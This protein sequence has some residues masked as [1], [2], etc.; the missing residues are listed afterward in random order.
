MFDSRTKTSTELWVELLKEG[1]EKAR[2][3]LTELQ[4]S[5]TVFMLQR[6][7]KRTDFGSIPFAF[8]YLNRVLKLGKI[9][10]QQILS[11]VADACLIMAGLFPERAKQ[12]NVSSSYFMELSQASY[13]E[14][15]D[16]SEY[17]R[18]KGEAA[19][20]QEVGQNVPKIARVLY[21]SRG[22]PNEEFFS[23]NGQVTLH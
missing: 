13:Q 12:L 16:L 18:R 21:A 23:I 9:E 11:D 6:F 22:K 7:V 20:Y 15:A 17:M 4:E 3:T 1:Q 14:H 5:H 2:I 8:Q 10:R 19:L